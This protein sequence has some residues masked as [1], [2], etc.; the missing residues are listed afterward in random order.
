VVALG[1]RRYKGRLEERIG[2]A[3]SPANAL[4]AVRA[5]LRGNRNVVTLGVTLRSV[6]IPSSLR[7]ERPLFVS[8]DPPDLRWSPE[9]GGPYPAFRG[10]MQVRESDGRTQLVLV[11]RYEAPPGRFAA[12]FD[13]SAGKRLA[14][15]TARALLAQFKN[16][17]ETDLTTVKLVFRV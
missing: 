17:L 5:F 9:P 16:A 6:G 1:R 2:V 13:S 8:F 3:G 10:T 15:A 7:L 12:A 4:Y 14:H 11:G